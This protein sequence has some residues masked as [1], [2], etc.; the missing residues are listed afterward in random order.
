MR[1]VRARRPAGASR[2]RV[3]ELLVA[4]LPAL[5]DGAERQLHLPPAATALVLPLAVSSFKVGAPILWQVA[6]V[7]LARLYGVAL[8]PAQLFTIAATASLVSFS[9]PGV[10]HGWLL[11]ITP[12]IVSI[13]VPPEGSAC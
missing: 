11:V 4:A 1:A 6:A 8:G 10:P 3:V 12:L 2:R 9:T 7:F 13:G 5:V